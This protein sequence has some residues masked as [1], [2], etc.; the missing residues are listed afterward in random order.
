MPRS[1]DS[2][3]IVPPYQGAA[4]EVRRGEAVRIVDVA[5]MQIGDVV[6]AAL[7]DPREAFSQ[8][9]TRLKGGRM[10]VG[11]GATLYSNRGRPMVHIES[12]PVGAHDIVGYPC[13]Q[14]RYEQ[15]FF[16]PEHPSCRSNLHALL[17]PYGYTIDD[18]PDPFNIF[19]DTRIYEGRRTVTEV[20]LS[21]AGDASIL[22]ALADILV[23]V[24]ACPQDLYPANGY[25]ITEL[26]L[27][28][29]SA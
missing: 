27:E 12:D 11:E 19:M 3:V 6:F 15:D 24:S 17:A 26:R 22:R 28:R 20:P 1:T 9:A 8:A 21:R 18:V 5:G 29:L 2:T 13:D 16:T 10:R 14:G 25:E 7:Q 4:I 23:A